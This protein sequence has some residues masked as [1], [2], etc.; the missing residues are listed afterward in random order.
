MPP[1]RSLAALFNYITQMSKYNFA[2]GVPMIVSGTANW[3]QITSA[4][5]VNELS[6]KYMVDLT[7]DE[8][9]LNEITAMGVLDFLQIRSQDGALKYEEPT[10]R[11]KTKNLPP[12]YDLQ[13][14]KFDGFIGNGSKL[15]CQITIK[16][17]EVNKKKGL[18]CYLN[19][20]LVLDL[21]EFANETDEE[22]FSGLPES[23]AND[24]FSAPA[25]IPSPKPSEAFTSP[26]N[27]E[28][29]NFPF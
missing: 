10:I 29:D 1:R 2:K 11:L 14:N 24:V 25:T 16:T 9:S 6:Q 18:T 5:G 15:R 23:D 8:K 12:V 22:F 13:K 28:D 3:A 20:A 26:A 27:D 19:K 21:V 7:L 4:S 17:W